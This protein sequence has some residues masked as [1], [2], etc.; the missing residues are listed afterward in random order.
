MSAPAASPLLQARMARVLAA[1]SPGLPTTEPHLGAALAEA[2]AGAGR[3]VRSALV[4]QAGEIRGLE[5]DRADDIACAIEYWHLASLM[6]DDL[7]SMDDA[8]QRRGL[9]CV[10]RTHG[11][12]TAILA[13]LALINRAYTLVQRAFAGEESDVRQR[14]GHLVDEALGTAGILSG[15][16]WDLRFEDGPGTARDVGR[17]ALRKTGALLW[18]AMSLP[19][20]ASGAWQAERRILRALSVY[21]ALVYQAMDD[22][23]DVAAPGGAPNKTPG[24]DAAL[25]RPNLAMALGTPLVLRRI[26]RLLGLIDVRLSALCVRDPKWNYLADW[27]ERLFMARYRRFAAN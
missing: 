4:L 26:K 15:Q 10:H 27:H 24:R 9:P 17:I 8:S 20:L 25:H 6:L 22:L 1:N 12:A 23:I 18:L 5:A 2:L 13:A 14:A 7:P 19:L 21:W 16:A 3:L 11:E